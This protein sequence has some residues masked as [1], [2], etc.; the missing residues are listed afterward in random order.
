[1][2]PKFKYKPRSPDAWD[3]RANQQG[4]S[5]VGVIKDDCKTFT[6]AKGDNHIRILPPTWEN[7]EHYG[8][9]IWVHYAVG[10]DRSSVLCLNKMQNKRCPLCEAKQKADRA[11]DEELSKELNAGRRVAIWLID[12]KEES[13]GPM[14]WTMPWTMDRDFVKLSRDRDGEIYLLDDPDEGYNI[15]F[16]KQGESIATKY[17]GIKLDR[18][19]TSVDSDIIEYIVEE[20]LPQV[21]VYLTYDEIKRIYEGG[22]MDEPADDPPAK[23]APADEKAEPKWKPRG[24]AAREDTPQSDAPDE[25]YTRGEDPPAAEKPEPTNDERKPNARAERKPDPEPDPP[26]PSGRTRAEELRAKYGNRS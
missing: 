26:K 6:P 2:A 19:P 12:R 16:E 24:R 4:G 17:V 18:K 15:S 21:L 23:D 8:L 7:A 13:K 1:M 14:V 5:G 20:P 25:G 22:G 11:G 10:P 9:D 3:K